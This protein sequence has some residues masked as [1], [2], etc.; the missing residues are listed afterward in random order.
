MHHFDIRI[1]QVLEYR[2]SLLKMALAN[3]EEWINTY[4][5]VRDVYVARQMKILF[6]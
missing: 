4:R 6:F 2:S 3:F 1:Y 5:A